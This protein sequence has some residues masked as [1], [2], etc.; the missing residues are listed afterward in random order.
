MAS[1]YL[2]IRSSAAES[3]AVKEAIASVPAYAVAFRQ[4]SYAGAYTNIDDYVA[5][6]NAL[7]HFR[8]VVTDDLSY[9]A[10]TAMQESAALYDDEANY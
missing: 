10:L 4:L 1:G 7:A 3:T 9:D 5:K 2:P 8:Q 6:A